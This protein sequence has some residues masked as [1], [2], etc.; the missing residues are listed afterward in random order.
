MVK[1]KNG[2]INLAERVFKHDR[3]VKEEFL[4]DIKPSTAKTIRSILFK[5]D[6]Y[7]DR[8]GKSIYDFTFEERD[9]FFISQFCNKSKGVINTT[10]SYLVKYINHCIDNNLVR[11]MENRFDLISKDDIDKYIN[12]TAMQM[13]YLSREEIKEAQDKLVNNCDKLILQLIPLSVRGRTELNNT[14]EELIN[15]RVKDAEES[16]ETGILHVWNNDGDR[17]PVKIDEETIELLKKTINDDS[18]IINNGSIYDKKGRILGRGIGEKCFPLNDTGYVFRTAGKNKKGK[19]KTNFFGS[20]MRIMKTWTMNP[21][22][23]VTN[24]YYSGIIDY[25]MQLRKEKGTELDNHDYIKIIDKFSYGKPQ[26]LSNKELDW[27]VPISKVK[28]MVE[29]YINRKL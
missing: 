18:Y 1:H 26:I 4:K 23:T 28:S 25:A 24:L 9:D 19:V 2:K 11:H 22:I 3:D 21:F 12:D 15:L 17:R 5:V 8:I 14:N 29:D 13:K 20:R 10:R 27:S 6:D 7:E 16:Y